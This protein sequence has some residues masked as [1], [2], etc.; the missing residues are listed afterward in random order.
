MIQLVFQCKA[1]RGLQNYK[2]KLIQKFDN[3][4][5]NYKNI[6]IGPSFRTSFGVL[7]VS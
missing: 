7:A 4:R 5:K 1:A 3:A 2:T 6:E